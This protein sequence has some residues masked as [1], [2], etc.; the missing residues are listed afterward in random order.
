[1]NK[2]IEKATLK[3]VQRME[4]N[5]KELNEAKESYNDSGYDRYL[6][7]ME[8][9]DKEY[10]EFKEFLHIQ[11]PDNSLTKANLEIDRLQRILATIKNK[12]FYMEADF[13]ANTHII[14]LKDL[15]RDI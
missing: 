8:Q 9:L 11:E 15:L 10:E 7:K 12:I 4:Q 3:I 13:P 2:Y 5:R 14:G 6:K 1:M